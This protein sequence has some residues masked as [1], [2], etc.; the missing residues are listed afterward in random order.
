MK[1]LDAQEA[2]HWRRIHN[3]ALLMQNYVKCL[4]LGKAPCPRNE[5]RPS[6]RQRTASTSEIPSKNLVKCRK[7]EH[8]YK[9]L[10][11]GRIWNF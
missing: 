2:V 1:Q 6:S 5:N 9:Q 7:L 10:C 8:L 3:L 11:C 4:L